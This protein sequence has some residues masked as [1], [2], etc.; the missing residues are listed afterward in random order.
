[1]V[2]VVAAMLCKDDCFLICQRPPHKTRGLLW[3]FVG[4]KVE[5][6]ETDEVALKRE[7]ME[8]L[9]V[10]IAIDEYRTSQIHEYPDMTI[11]LVLY[12]G[13]VVE[14]ELQKLEHADLRWIPV[15]EIPNYTFCPADIDIMGYLYKHGLYNTSK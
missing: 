8:E 6:G 2:R 10:E 13:H 15:T 12:R 7:C 5:D 1:M 11:E 4:G 3:E 9:G 14:G